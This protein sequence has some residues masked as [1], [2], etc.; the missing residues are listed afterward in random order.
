M[1]SPHHLLSTKGS[2]WLRRWPDLHYYCSRSLKR[3]WTIFSRIQTRGNLS[4]PVPSSPCL[5]PVQWA[6]WSKYSLIFL[7]FFCNEIYFHLHNKIR[8][9][10]WSMAKLTLAHRVFSNSG[11]EVKVRSVLLASSDSADACY[12]HCHLP[13]N[14]GWNSS[15]LLAIGRNDVKL[16]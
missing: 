8:K 12:Y 13:L 9:A 11:R 15:S 4:S 3:L 5:S 6:P 10:V 1:Y 14:S 2:W 7:L 16:A